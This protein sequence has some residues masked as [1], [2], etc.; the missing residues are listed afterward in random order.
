MSLWVLEIW[1]SISGSAAPCPPPRAHAVVAVSR[2]KYD[3]CIQE[4]GTTVPC[5]SPISSTPPPPTSPGLMHVSQTARASKKGKSKSITHHKSIL[6]RTDAFDR[7]VRHVIARRICKFFVQSPELAAG[8]GA[9]A[10]DWTGAG[11]GGAAATGEES[12]AQK[13]AGHVDHWC[14]S[15]SSAHSESSHLQEHHAPQEHHIRST[16]CSSSSDGD[17][18]GRG[19]RDGVRA[20]ASHAQEHHTFGREQ[21]LPAPA[22]G[23]FPHTV[24]EFNEGSLVQKVAPPPPPLSLNSFLHA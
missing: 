7:R 2:C 11:A 20:G 10:G 16:G 4:S 3:T 5:S 24:F 6:H 1:T 15:S 22:R 23:A 21:R 19:A 18:D 13:V 8:T 17:Q 9:R 12:M 14:S